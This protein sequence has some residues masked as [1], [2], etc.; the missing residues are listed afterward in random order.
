MKP[1][2]Q[3]ILKIIEQHLKEMPSQ[4]FGQILFNL[5]INQFADKENPEKENYQ[6]RDIYNDTDE[7]ILKRLKRLKLFIVK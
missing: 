3:E 2:H 4:R 1:E 6:L 7:D 5:N